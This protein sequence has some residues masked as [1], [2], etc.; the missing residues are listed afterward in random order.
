MKKSRNAS[1]G[2]GDR[3]TVQIDVTGTESELELL[4][5]KLVREGFEKAPCSDDNNDGTHTWSFFL[6]SWRL[7]EFNSL[8]REAKAQRKPS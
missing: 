5:T 3:G 4:E 8:Y 1:N 2:C 7:D 6:E